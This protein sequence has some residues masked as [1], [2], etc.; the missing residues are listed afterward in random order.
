[1]DPHSARIAAEIAA[2]SLEER[3]LRPRCAAPPPAPARQSTAA[4][5]EAF[6]ERQNSAVDCRNARIAGGQRPP[7]PQSFVNE[8]S[9]AILGR[10][11][12]PPPPAAAAPPASPPASN[13]L[14]AWMVELGRARMR[15]MRLEAARLAESTNA[16]LTFEPSFVSDAAARE[17]AAARKDAI[18]AGNHAKAAALRRQIRGKRKRPAKVKPSRVPRMTHNLRHILTG[19]QG[20]RTGKTEFPESPAE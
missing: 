19:F 2:P 16:K 20:K 15:E 18:L 6:M 4:G 14:P 17:A 3:A 13:A 5:F 1:M 10:A 7:R 9:R 8:Q 11:A 12:P